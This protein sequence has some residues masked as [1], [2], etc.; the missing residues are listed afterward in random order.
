MLLQIYYNDSKL[1]FEMTQH[2]RRWSLDF[3][4]IYADTWYFLELSWGV[5]RGFQAFV[6][7]DQ[8]KE[9]AYSDAQ[10]V[11]AKRRTTQGRFLIGFADDLDVDIP[12]LCGDFIVDEVELW[13]EDRSTLLAFG[14]IE[15]GTETVTR[16]L[17]RVSVAYPKG[18]EGPGAP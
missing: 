15:R 4:N 13:F 3:D 12:V 14:Y 2:S 6:N 7:R 5:Q 11:G 17:N 9:L 18:A 10:T 8:S 16:L 1:V